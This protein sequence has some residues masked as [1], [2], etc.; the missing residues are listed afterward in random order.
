VRSIA[1]V[2]FPTEQEV[3]VVDQR[4][5]TDV[6]DE[7][8]TDHHAAL[9]LLDRIA[10]IND[11]EERRNLAD[12]VI[13]EVVR[14]SVSEE[15]YVYPAMREYLPDGEQVVEHDTG[16]H[17]ELEEIMKQLEGV[18]ASEPRFDALVRELTDKLRHHARD[19]ETEQFP[20]LREWV[21]RDELVRL[22][23]KVDT[24]KKVAPTRP[25]PDAPNSEL[26]HKIVGPGVGLVDRLRDKLTNRPNG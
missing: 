21:P 15:M 12:T 26:F 11:A 25:H 18:A 2:P 14:H 22:R 16:E 20:R 5:D 23:E 17:K 3:N 8:V 7:L 19:E 13:S 10:S 24:V 9:Q 6:I 1:A 4:T